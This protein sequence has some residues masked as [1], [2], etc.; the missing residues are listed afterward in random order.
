MTPEDQDARSPQAEPARQEAAASQQVPPRQPFHE[1]PTTPLPPVY[2]APPTSAPA[3]ASSQSDSAGAPAQPT[4]QT[5]QYPGQQT[6]RFPTDAYPTQQLNDP[7]ASAGGGFGGGDGPSGGSA[8]GTGDQSGTAK[9]SGGSIAK[10]V[11]IAALVSALVGGGAGA[12]IGWQVSNHG[13]PSVSASSGSSNVT[14]NNPQSVT[15]IT[16]AAAKASP[17][18]VTISATTGSESGTGSG[19]VL[20]N[21]GHIVTN[22]HVVTLDG[23]SSKAQLS[24][25]LSDGSIYEASVVGLDPTT[26][27]AVIQIKNPPALT[28]ITIA[29]SAKLNVGDTA[30]A[31]GA[32]QGLQNTVTSGIVSALN[33]AISL[34]SSAAQDGNEGED[35]ST[36]QGNGFDFWNNFGSGGG[37]QQQQP[38]SQSGSSSA[39]DNSIYLSVIQTDAAINPGN[40]GGPLVNDAGELIGLNVAI[41]TATSSS[42]QSS[43]SGSIGLGF[44]I[45]ANVV[46]RVTGE[47]MESGK[48][49]H[50]Q[51][52]ATVSSATAQDGATGAL[53]KDVTSGGPAD[54]AGLRAGDIITKVDDVR[55]TSSSHLI[56]T[57]R[58]NGPDT[59]IT[60]EYVRN[61]QTQSTEITLEASA[62]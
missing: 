12:A 54:Q 2:A 16:A 55:I 62:Q 6:Q 27:L 59:K 48:A 3:F 22:T 7:S 50:G 51:L 30:V 40:S 39:A 53:I 17:S 43:S 35:G 18:V 29:D 23:A 52:G 33:R 38:R 60:V 42:G 9:R 13:E 5:P 31:I 19:V 47:L 15:Q 26:D 37:S 4:A 28:P 57:V 24:V 34:S 21:S 25:T 1:Q 49:E 20:D 56:G 14:I 45:P 8:D 41:A 44:A 61:G 46:K 58:Q 36:D 10:V 11:G 32:P